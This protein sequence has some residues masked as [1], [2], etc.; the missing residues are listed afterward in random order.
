MPGISMGWAWGGYL[1][2]FAGKEPSS[3]HWIKYRVT[4]LEQWMTDYTQGRLPPIP[5][6]IL[7][8]AGRW[9]ILG[10]W[11]RDAAAGQKTEERHSTKNPAPARYDPSHLRNFTPTHRTKKQNLMI[12]AAPLPSPHRGVSVRDISVRCRDLHG[13]VGIQKKLPWRWETRC[14]S[15]PL[16]VPCGK[17]ILRARHIGL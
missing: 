4:E 3:T 7:P 10:V 12:A 17:F 6:P 5:P 13:G 16:N 2:Y 9:P 8:R 14:T 11:E 1:L 15:Y